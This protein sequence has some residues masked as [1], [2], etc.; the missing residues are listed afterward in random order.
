MTALKIAT[1]NVNSIRRRLPLLLDWLAQELIKNNWRLKPMHKLIM[2]SSTYMQSS[3]FDAADAK[4]DPENVWLW[5]RT[6]QRRP[7]GPIP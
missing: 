1:Y 3:R 2:T 7:R 6:P 4:L 5:R